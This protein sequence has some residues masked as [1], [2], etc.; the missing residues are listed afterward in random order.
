MRIETEFQEEI[1]FQDIADLIVE[2]IAAPT[3][4]ARSTMPGYYPVAVMK[5]VCTSRPQNSGQRIKLL[6]WSYLRREAETCIAFIKNCESECFSDI[7]LYN[8]SKL[9]DTDK[10]TTYEAYE[11]AVQH[12]LNFDK[13]LAE[14]RK[15][16]MSQRELVA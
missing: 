4:D 15:Y 1:Y 8:R 2:E 6:R 14:I 11:D 3:R 7:S 5:P 10:I 13:Q 12:R 9:F 16:N